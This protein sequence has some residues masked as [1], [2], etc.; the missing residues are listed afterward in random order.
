MAAAEQAGI[1]HVERVEVQSPDAKPRQS[2]S[3]ITDTEGNAT[4]TSHS[5]QDSK[6]LE[7]PPELRNSIYRYVLVFEA[8]IEIPDLG[9]LGRPALLKTCQQITGE[10][11]SIYYAENNFHAYATDNLAGVVRWASHLTVPARL[12]VRSIRLQLRLNEGFKDIIRR[13]IDESLGGNDGESAMLMKKAL[14]ASEQVLA[15]CLGALYALCFVGISVQALCWPEGDAQQLGDSC[16]SGV[17]EVDGVVACISS[18]YTRDCAESMEARRARCMERVQRQRIQETQR[19]RP[20]SE[21]P[22]KLETECI[23]KMGVEAERLL[24]V[25]HAPGDAKAPGQT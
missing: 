17:V 16:V 11:T 1:P 18:M 22:D 12:A 15:R 19:H 24:K 23:K 10:A 7:L 25:W 14:C 8:N 4:A 13:Y 20:S 21:D 2:P 9:K 5:I 6:L 3:R